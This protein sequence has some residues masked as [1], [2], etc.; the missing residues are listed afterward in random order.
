MGSRLFLEVEIKVANTLVYNCKKLIEILIKEFMAITPY[1][2]LKLFSSY[3][4]HGY[5]FP[6]HHYV[7]SRMRSL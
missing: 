7:F 5:Q 1:V 3:C 2:L 4:V 6:F